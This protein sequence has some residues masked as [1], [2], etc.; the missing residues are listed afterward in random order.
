MFQHW[1][2]SSNNLV[3]EQWVWRL[4]SGRLEPCT[5]DLPPAPEVLLNVIRCK[6]KTD[7]LSQRC[8]CRKHGLEC[9]L[10]CD[11]CKGLN[12][13][14]SP[15]LEL[16]EDIPEPQDNTLGSVL[17]WRADILEVGAHPYLLRP[18]AH[19]SSQGWLTDSP[20]EVMIGNRLR[21]VPKDV[22]LCPAPCGTRFS[23]SFPRV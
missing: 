13:T 11:E 15:S 2:D 6:C 12:C 7:C 19:P 16:V 1:I 21:A 9:S 17:G 14:N 20:C 10:A 18:S 4:S 23:C 3:P 22:D 5:T 8:S